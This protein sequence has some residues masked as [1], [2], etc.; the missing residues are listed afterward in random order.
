MKLSSRQEESPEWSRLLVAAAVGGLATLFVA[1]NFFPEEK[2]VRH[3]IHA[4][5]DAGDD[6]FVRTMGQLLGPPLLKGNKVTVFENGDQIFPELLKAIRSARRT[7]TF[8]NFLWAEGEIT[9]ASP[10]R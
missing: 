6:V 5:Y 9:E 10:T 1:R 7:I 2:K 8:E 4:R 3:R